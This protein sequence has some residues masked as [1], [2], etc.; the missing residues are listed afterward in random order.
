M[1]SDIC[2]LLVMALVIAALQRLLMPKYQ[3]QIVEGAFTEEYYKDDTPHQVLILGDCEA[4]ENISTVKLWEMYG[5]TS[6][7]R[8]NAN[9]LPSQSYFLL[10]EAL[11]R[12][13]PEVILFSVSALQE[14]GQTN[15]AYNRMT[16][17][18]MRWS[19]LKVQA[20]L[21]SAMPEEHFI[22]YVFPILRFHDRWKE[23]DDSDL[24]YY[25]GG[26][27]T[28]HN[29]YY[30]RADVRPA[31][32][33]PSIRRL[34]DPMLPEAS[35]DYL[36]RIRE[37]CEEQ[38]IQLMLFKAPSLYPVWHEEWD[39]QIREY[40][41]RNGLTYSNCLEHSEETGIDYAA[42]T[43]DGG[44]H[45]NVYGAEKTAAYLGSILVC[46]YGLKSKKD[47]AQI[48]QAYEARTAAYIKEKTK[49]EEEFREYGYIP[50]YTQSEEKG[51]AP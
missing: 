22:E 33:F 14:T 38:G 25:R 4:Y 42:D 26:P 30:L 39:R 10:K 27:L 21:A 18:G 47:D 28:T 12:E 37:L 5:V 16:L 7:I 15:E 17:D 19:D 34:P 51:G 48:S 2:S 20:I 13:K 23:L 24:K 36:D 43:Y 46:K 9:Q 40:A 45:M 31:G 11:K 50:R 32:E 6:Y 49:Q 44:M 1:V 35:M 41:E 3:G 8:G 29:G